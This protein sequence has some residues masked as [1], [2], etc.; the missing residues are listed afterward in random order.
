MVTLCEPRC[1][2]ISFINFCVLTFVASVVYLP[3]LTRIVKIYILT[4]WSVAFPIEAAAISAY[5]YITAGNPR[6]TLVCGNISSW[7]SCGFIYSRAICESKVNFA[8]Y[9][10]KYR[11]WIPYF[12]F[13][14]AVAIILINLKHSLLHQTKGILLRSSSYYHDECAWFH[15]PADGP[16]IRKIS[17]S[18]CSSIKFVDG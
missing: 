18:I 6:F 1:R 14:A 7:V 8:Y 2:G 3:W 15:V 5:R 9:S 13:K 16:R 17:A 4:D 12:R 11:T 10:N